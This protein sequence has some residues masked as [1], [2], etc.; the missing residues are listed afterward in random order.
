[1]PVGPGETGVSLA[2]A[3]LGAVVRPVA[4]HE[5]ARRIRTV[6]LD[7]RAVGGRASRVTRAGGAAQGALCGTGNRRTIG[8]SGI[9]GLVSGQAAIQGLDVPRLPPE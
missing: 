2:R 9:F 3:F 1:M 6:G 5:P 7:E 8:S 4:C